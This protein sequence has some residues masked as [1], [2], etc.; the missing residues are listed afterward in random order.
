MRLTD[1]RFWFLFLVTANMVATSAQ[2]CF[3]VDRI[4]KDDFEK[5]KNSTEKY[6]HDL[7]G[8]SVVENYIT[9]RIL[10]DARI[11]FEKLDSITRLENYDIGLERE[12]YESLFSIQSLKL[13]KSLGMYW[14]ILPSIH[15]NELYCYDMTGKFL[16]EM[17][18]PF[19]VS[20]HGIMV[21][22]KGFDCDGY[23]QLHF[24]KQNADMLWEFLTFK[25]QN[26]PLPYITDYY[27]CL[28][29]D[30][31]ATS[32][33]VGDNLLFISSQKPSVTH[34]EQIYLRITL[35]EE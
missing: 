15:D 3:S 18:M 21:S 16:G 8:G 22:Q 1:K 31:P 26:I 27:T 11:R 19:A 25:N 10:F 29:S 20:L 17:L 24:Y 4:S 23:L 13:N 2:T 34:I 9:S 32:F 6:V 35:S 33:W 5:A 12:E 28:E 7:R 30:L 14:F